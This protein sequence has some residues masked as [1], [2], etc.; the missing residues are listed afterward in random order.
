MFVLLQRIQ[1]LP[2]FYE[3]ELVRAIQVVTEKA[4]ID[5]DPRS[6]HAKVMVVGEEEGKGG[7]E[8]REGRD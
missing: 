6:P 7:E 8:E 3:S 4:A 1:W 5:T 2:L